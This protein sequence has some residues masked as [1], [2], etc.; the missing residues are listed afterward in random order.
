MSALTPE[1]FERH[2]ERLHHWRHDNL[3]EVLEDL[4]LLQAEVLE[5]Q[6][7]L[8]AQAKPAISLTVH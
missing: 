6:A 2:R 4:E 8:A 7:E 3:H 1:W 5:L